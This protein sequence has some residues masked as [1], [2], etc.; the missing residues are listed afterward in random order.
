MTA[1]AF[2][3]EVVRTDRK[4]SV[5][6]E[7]R[8]EVVRVRVPKTLPE[9][10]IRELIEKRTPWIHAK[11]KERAQLPVVTPKEYISGE[12]FAFLGRNYRLKVLKGEGAPAVTMQGNYLV[13]AVSAADPAPQRTVR[14]HLHAWY[15]EQAWQRLEG[16]TARYAKIIGV[17][18]AAVVVGDYKSRWGACSARGRISYNWKIILAPAPHSGLCRHPRTL[19]PA[20]AQPLPQLLAPCGAPRPPLAR[21]PP[22][23]KNQPAG[24]VGA[25]CGSDPARLAALGTRPKGR[26]KPSRYARWCGF[27]I[28][29]TGVEMP[30]IRA[31]I[32]RERNCE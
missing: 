8:G 30:S 14:A 13:A 12:A 23:A 1:P 22:L 24:G 26:V 18:P 32:C 28:P 19:P 17:S 10:R 6:I 4:R 27:V 3:I 16:K 5:S 2:Q 11:L 15:R 25:A 9:E 20:G 21:V 31:L 29:Y 7:L